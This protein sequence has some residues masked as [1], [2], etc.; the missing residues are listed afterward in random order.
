MAVTEPAPLID[1]LMPRFDAVER[2]AIRIAAPPEVV[3]A[4]LR[5]VDLL[6]SRLIRWLIALRSLPAALGRPR[7]RAARVAL[8][9]DRMLEHGFVLLGERPGRELALGVVGRFWTPGGE[10]V[11]VDAEGFRAFDRAGYAKVVWDF[12]LAPEAGGATRLSTE[13]RIWCLDPGSRRRFG[14]YWLVV[15]PFS[16]LIRLVLLRAVA[17]EATR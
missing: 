14:R 5:R 1:E 7:A 9:L 10:R 17:Q 3:Y 8:T 4:A 15:R 11:P 13:T 12:R 16:G 6:G 2:H